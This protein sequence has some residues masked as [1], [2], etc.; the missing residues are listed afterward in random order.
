MLVKHETP[1]TKRLQYHFCPQIII[2]SV[3]VL[4]WTSLV[5]CK[6]FSPIRLRLPAATFSLDLMRD[7]S[8]SR[9]VD[10]ASSVITASTSTADGMA[11]NSIKLLTG[12]SH[13]DLAKAVANRWGIVNSSEGF[14]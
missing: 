6:L 2:V 4:D 7:Y 14:S 12:N 5:I 13:P 10:N 1:H 3:S 8:W 9:H 11:S